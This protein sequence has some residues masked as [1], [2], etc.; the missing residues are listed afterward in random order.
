MRK[1]KTT[2]GSFFLSFPKPL[3]DP[4]S[5]KK[6]H[7][8]PQAK[9][10]TKCQFLRKSLLPVSYTHLDVYKRQLLLHLTDAYDLLILCNPNNPTS[11]AILKSDMERILAHCSQNSIFV[12]VDE[13]YAEF[14]PS[15]SEITAIPFTKHY[16]N[17]MVIR[18]VSKF[19]AA[20]GLRSVSYTHLT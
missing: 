17:L 16:Q 2:F 20:P 6:Y 9:P 4:I 12:M 15:I 5:A 14:A 19:F 13:T 1:H 7:S 3:P 18:G 11:S 8:K 10:G